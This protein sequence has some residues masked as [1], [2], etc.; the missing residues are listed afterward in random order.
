MLTSSLAIASDTPFRRFT[1]TSIRFRMSSIFTLKSFWSVER[2]LD[3]SRM[4]SFSP[5]QPDSTNCLAPPNFISKRFGSSMSYSV[6]LSKRNASVF[7]RLLSLENSASMETS[8]NAEIAMIFSTSGMPTS[9]SHFVTACRET[10]SFSASCS[11]DM[12]ACLRMFFRF[13][14]NVIFVPSR[15]FVL[16]RFPV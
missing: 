13:S 12:P 9:V 16:L 2:V 5:S 7:C 11:C 1:S 8:N 15:P 10:P 4:R 14:A 3:A 6:T